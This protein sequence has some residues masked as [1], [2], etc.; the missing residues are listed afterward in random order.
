MAKFSAN[1]RIRDCW[2]QYS[3]KGTR[4]VL[5]VFSVNGDQY[6]L[7]PDDPANGGVIEV[8]SNI[9]DIDAGWELDT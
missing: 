4:T 7:G 9:T 5:Y 6:D 8:S 1:D 2:N 3:G